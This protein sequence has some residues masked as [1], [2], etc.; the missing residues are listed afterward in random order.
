[1][2]EGGRIDATDLA[3]VRLSPDGTRLI[4]LL[5]DQSGRQIS[6]SLPTTCVNAMLTAVPG[7]IEPGTVH[8]LDSWAV[9]PAANG[10]EMVLTLRTREVRAVSFGTRPSQVQGLATVATYGLASQTGRKLLH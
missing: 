6:L 3:E 7:E 10:R 9:S 2:S 5:R 4:L 8:A 1:M